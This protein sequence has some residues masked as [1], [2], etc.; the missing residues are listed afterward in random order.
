MKYHYRIEAEDRQPQPEKI[1]VNTLANALTQRRAVIQILRGMMLDVSGPEQAHFMVHAVEP[2]IGN[3][4][5]EKQNH[6]GPPLPANH[7]AQA[8]PI[9]FVHIE[10]GHEGEGFWNNVDQDGGKGHRQG[11]PHILVHI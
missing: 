6:P 10:Q 8:E 7:I 9:G 2:V 11:C 4:V 5:G 1:F 3:I